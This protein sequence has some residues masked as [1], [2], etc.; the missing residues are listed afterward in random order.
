MEDDVS[1]A[2]QVVEEVSITYMFIT[3]YKV[4][5]LWILH[6]NTISYMHHGPKNIGRAMEQSQVEVQF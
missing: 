2:T 4:F 1:I 6:N 3:H 5:E